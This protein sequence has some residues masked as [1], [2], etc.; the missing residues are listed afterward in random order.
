MGADRSAVNA[1][2]QVGQ[3][4]SVR[5]GQGRGLVTGE[6]TI[7]VAQGDK[8]IRIGPGSRQQLALALRQIDGEG[9]GRVGVA[10]ARQCRGQDT[11][12]GAAIE[13]AGERVGVAVARYPELAAAP[14]GTA[15]GNQPDFE[16]TTGES[17]GRLEDDRR[18]GVAGVNEGVDAITG[19]R[20]ARITDRGADAD[21]GYRT[22][23]L[24]HHDTGLTPLRD[25]HPG[26][27]PGDLVPP[28]RDGRVNPGHDE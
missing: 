20:L 19:G 23:H 7:A 6:L 3:V 9:V 12:A 4:V 28:A 14:I 5:R 2:T 26:A 16:S 27:G 13:R 24:C 15:R 17:G 11:L 10:V 22:G 25:R 18:V 1:A 8:I 21:R